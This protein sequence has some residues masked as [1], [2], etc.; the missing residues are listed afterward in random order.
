[1]V[2]HF[3]NNGSLINDYNEKNLA[4]K[5]ELFSGSSKN[6]IPKSVDP[7]ANSDTNTLF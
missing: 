7:F 6:Y 1:M 5:V 3:K 4:H 2:P